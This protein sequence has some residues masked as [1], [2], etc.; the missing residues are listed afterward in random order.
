VVIPKKS[1]HTLGCGL[2]LRTRGPKTRTNDV[3]VGGA[4]NLI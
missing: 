3:L 1:D 4:R 2:G